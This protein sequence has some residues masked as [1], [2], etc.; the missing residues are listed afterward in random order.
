MK[1]QS[2]SIQLD[3]EIEIGIRSMGIRN[4]FKSNEVDDIESTEISY[5]DPTEN[6]LTVKL[7][8]NYI[9][10]KFNI[11]PSAYYKI[12]AQMKIKYFTPFS[13]SK[14]IN[15]PPKNLMCTN[16]P[17]PV[18]PEFLRENTSGFTEIKN[19]QGVELDKYKKLRSWGKIKTY[20]MYGRKFVK[21]C[22]I[23]VMIKEKCE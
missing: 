22:D 1:I 5:E 21:N 9:M 2:D 7:S 23:K 14:L 8:A 13:V 15:E 17:I 18:K 20:K 3:R 4:M 12:M 10:H 6:D 16:I 11:T 19:I